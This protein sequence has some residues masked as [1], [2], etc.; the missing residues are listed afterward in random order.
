MIKSSL[1]VLS[2]MRVMLPS[3]LNLSSTKVR[4]FLDLTPK[5]LRINK[6]RL[7]LNKVESLMTSRFLHQILKR[8]LFNK[9]NLDKIPL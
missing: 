4:T 5:W 8:L 1:M 3:T 6:R 2:K 7:T 9:R